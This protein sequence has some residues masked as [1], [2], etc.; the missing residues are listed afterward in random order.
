MENVNEESL[1]DLVDNRLIQF[2]EKEG[3]KPI[4]FLVNECTLDLLI[5]EVKREFLWYVKSNSQMKEE[6]VNYRGVMFEID[7]KI[8][9]KNI[10]LE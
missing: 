2:M 10:V 9:G 3:R 1:L 7:E 6:G 4:K 5:N 8:E